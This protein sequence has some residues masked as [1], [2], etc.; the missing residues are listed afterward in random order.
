MSTEPRLG[1]GCEVGPDVSLGAASEGDPPTIGR[2][3]TIRS[4][5]IIYPDVTVG[6]RLSTGHNVLIREETTIGD[7]VTVGTNTV[8]DGASTIGSGVSMQTG[9]YVP[10]ETTIGDDVFLGPHAVLTNDPYPIRQDV[11]LA[12]PILEA[13]VSVGANATLLPDV[14]VGEGS[15]V[16]AGAVVTEDVPPNRLAVGAPATHRRLP[17]PLQGDNEIR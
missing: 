16:A 5:T 14:A 3:S 15:F 9:V 6:D 2:E 1:E 7:D 10:R 17:E 4:G 8:I 13:G 12:G 11:D